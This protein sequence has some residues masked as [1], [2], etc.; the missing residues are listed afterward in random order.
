MPKPADLRRAERAIAKARRE[1]EKAKLREQQA[2]ES[3]A[4]AQA[5]AEAI[6]NEKARQAS[7]HKAFSNQNQA[8][9]PAIAYEILKT[10]APLCL[11]VNVGSRANLE[12]LDK[13]TVWHIL[14]IVA[15]SQSFLDELWIPYYKSI[16][17][18]DKSLANEF[19]LGKHPSLLFFS[20]QPT[21]STVDVVFECYGSPS[22][23]YHDLNKLTNN[24][25][26]R[27]SFE[28]AIANFPRALDTRTPTQQDENRDGATFDDLEG[29]HGAG[30]TELTFEDK[31]VGPTHQVASI[32]SDATGKNLPPNP[33][34]L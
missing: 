18:E 31:D 7:I 5:E 22:D 3:E 29:K 34:H 24:R 14:R 21:N 4:A 30:P 11:I 9:A 15:A 12:G 1:R 33:F 16:Y 6:L 26:S 19:L 25:K 23:L 10:Q 27:Q 28:D 17:S 32:I 2:Q 8:R 20:E 13:E